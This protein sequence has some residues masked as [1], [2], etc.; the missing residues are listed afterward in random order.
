MIAPESWIELGRHGAFTTSQVATLVG[1][2]SEQVASWLG[3]HPPLIQPDLPSVAGRK[4]VSF[5]GLIEAR[6]VAYLLKEGVARRRLAALMSVLRSRTNDVHPLA[7]DRDLVTNGWAVY[8][9]SDGKIVNLLNECY[10]SDDIIKPTLSGRV[11][12]RSG[13]AAWLEPYPSDLPLVRIEPARAFGR[14]VIVDGGVT[15]PTETLAS[16]ARIEGRAEAAD[17]YGVCEEAVDQAVIFEE[18]IAA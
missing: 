8:E 6:A 7:R 5:E 11:I 3:G 15:V 9:V 17:W 1:A 18:R 2:T 4:A 13:R 16:S 12:F 10:A 14:P